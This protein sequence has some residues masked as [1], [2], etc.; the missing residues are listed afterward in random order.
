MAS[1]HH[2]PIGKHFDGRHPASGHLG[3]GEE[4]PWLDGGLRPSATLGPTR[5][6]WRGWESLCAGWER[7]L[8]DAGLRQAAWGHLLGTGDTGVRQ[9]WGDGAPREGGAAGSRG[10]GQKAKDVLRPSLP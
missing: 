5:D 9:T 10:C 2:C 1:A 4:W 7:E 3:D 8:L 6:G